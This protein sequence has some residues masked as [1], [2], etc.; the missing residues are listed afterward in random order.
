MTYTQ[1][2]VFGNPDLEMDSLPVKLLPELR[3]AFPKASFEP[4]DPNEDW[5]VPRDM[6]VIDTVVGLKEVQ[7][8]TDMSAFMAAPRVTCHDFDAYANLLFLK[9]LKKIDST[10]IVG[11]PAGI[12]KETLLPELHK[13]LLKLLE[14]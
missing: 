13:A 2:F 7:V 4:L 1:V 3:S 11:I 9:K 6:L 14:S 12:P 8:F 5:N 10:T